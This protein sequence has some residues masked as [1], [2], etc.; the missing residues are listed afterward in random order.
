MMNLRNMF[1][2]IFCFVLASTAKTQP[3][4][5]TY[6]SDVSHFV[7]ANYSKK[8]LSK[9]KAWS[10][11]SSTEN[12]IKKHIKHLWYRG[13]IIS[14]EGASIEFM[15]FSSELK[16]TGEKRTSG[17]ILFSHRG[18]CD[19][20]LQPVLRYITESRFNYDTLHIKDGLTCSMDK[21][22]LHF[23]NYSPST[24]KVLQ[25]IDTSLTKVLKREYFDFYFGDINKATSTWQ[26][27]FKTFM[28]PYSDALIA[29]LTKNNIPGV[30]RLIALPNK[31]YSWFLAEGL[32][33]YNSLHPCLTPEQ[34][35]IIDA[36]NGKDGMISFR[37]A[38]NL[39]E[40]YKF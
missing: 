33:Y 23:D 32:W 8:D 6:V 22:Y 27:E 24:N 39:K 35:K 21:I 7:S 25:D 15:F 20:L 14:K 9:I 4:L 28:Q 16:A 3:S 13:K 17:F 2:A 10:G 19:V 26:T 30:F 37:P 36:Y 12:N 31:G 18:D 38:E 11:S 29:L 5:E 34:M 1:F 40:V